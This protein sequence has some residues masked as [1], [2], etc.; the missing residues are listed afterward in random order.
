[1]HTMGSENS[2]R[3]ILHQLQTPTVPSL[4]HIID[5]LVKIRDDC[6]SP[7]SLSVCIDKYDSEYIISVILDLIQ[8]VEQQ[9]QYKGCSSFQKRAYPASM[10][11]I[12]D[13]LYDIYYACCSRDDVGYI[14]DAVWDAIVRISG[15]IL[16]KSGIH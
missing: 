8:K 16:R 14:S 6:L 11:N 12:I 3:N 15:E 7:P 2:M 5:Q 1:M 13:Q 4:I 9:S 10:S